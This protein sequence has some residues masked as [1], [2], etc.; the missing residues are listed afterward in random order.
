MGPQ[1]TQS[2]VDSDPAV[3]RSSGK[4]RTEFTEGDSL[5][6]GVYLY[7]GPALG[8]RYNVDTGFASPFIVPQHGPL[9]V[10]LMPPK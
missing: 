2:W 3:T 9:C 4:A 5:C 1:R 7:K 10:R 6:V 8:G